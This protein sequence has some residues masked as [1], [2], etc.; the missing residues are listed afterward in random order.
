MARFHGSQG[1]GSRTIGGDARSAKARF[2]A[3][4]VQWQEDSLPGLPTL[5]R[6]GL[7]VDT[8]IVQAVWQHIAP[9]DRRRA[10]RKLA[11]TLRSGGLLILCLRH[12][13]PEEEREFYPVTQP[14][15]S[16]SQVNKAWLLCA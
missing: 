9:E 8:V 14:K 3:S 2:D 7:S 10:F 4:G 11:G 6:A 15:S 16:D 1:G 13:P 12:G 5:T